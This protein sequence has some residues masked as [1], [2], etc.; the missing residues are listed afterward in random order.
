MEVVFSYYGN[1]KRI[2]IVRYLVD[3]KYYA[4][5][6]DPTSS[7]FDGKIPTNT[8]YWNE[9]GETFDSVATGLLLAEVAYIDNLGVR[10]FSGNARC[11]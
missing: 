4:A 8:D 5:R 10:M 2:D 1:E 11:W 6:V 3:G 9:F 7:P